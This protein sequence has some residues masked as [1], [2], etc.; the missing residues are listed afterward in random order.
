[1]SDSNTDNAAQEHPRI[2]EAPHQEERP[3]DICGLWYPD[4]P[5]SQDM[6]FMTQREIQVLDSMRQVKEEAREVQ[7]KLREMMESREE[8]KELSRRLQ[9]LQARWREL[10]RERTAAA[11]ER[12]E[13]LGHKEP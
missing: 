10:D 3:C 1:M 9:D 8:G 13:K 12:M 11:D 2:H 7:K 4:D 5:Q 6:H